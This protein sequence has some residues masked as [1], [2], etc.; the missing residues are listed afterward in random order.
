MVEQ[1]LDVEKI[2]PLSDEPVEQDD[3][4]GQSHDKVAEALVKLISKNK[5]G[6]AIGLEGSWGSGKSTVINIA[7]DKL[8]D[9][10][11]EILFFPFD[12]WARQGDPIRRS[13]LELLI[14]FLSEKRIINKKNW[15][16]TL[17]E[18]QSR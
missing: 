9:K 17:K 4:K 16:K 3:F 18:I 14:N 8:E 12:A 6:Y 1:E 15:S 13:F 11:E 7:E 10:G 5:G 2:E